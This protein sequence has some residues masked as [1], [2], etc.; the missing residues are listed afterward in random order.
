MV[1]EKVFCQFFKVKLGLT[2]F[3]NAN[4]TAC[5]FWKTVLLQITDLQSV[6]IVLKMLKMLS[7]YVVPFLFENDLF[8]LVFCH[9]GRF[10]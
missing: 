3:A 2:Y 8:Y 6:K 10:F 4:A 5:L 7:H 1:K 9:L